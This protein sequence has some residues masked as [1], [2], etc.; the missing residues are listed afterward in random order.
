MRDSAVKGSG[1]VDG[2][3]EIGHEPWWGSNTPRTVSKCYSPARYSCD[4][5]AG[6]APGADRRSQGDWRDISSAGSPV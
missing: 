1:W 4:Q 5:L 3:L 2:T 6:S